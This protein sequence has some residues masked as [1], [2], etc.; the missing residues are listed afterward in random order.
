MIRSNG[1]ADRLD[2]ISQRIE[3]LVLSRTVNRSAV[4]L[5][6]G[7]AA[8]GLPVVLASLLCNRTSPDVHAARP[9]A[10][11]ENA[12]PDTL[13][14][15]HRALDFGAVRVTDRFMWCIAIANRSRRDA[16]IDELSAGCN[17]TTISPH[18]L[19]IPPG[20][21]R[22]VTLVID[23]RRTAKNLAN[24][25]STRLTARL[26]GGMVQRWVVK[27][28]PIE[29]THE[30]SSTPLVFRLP[31]SEAGDPTPAPFATAERR[32]IFPVDAADAVVRPPIVEMEAACEN[33]LVRFNCSDPGACPAGRTAIT[34][35]VDGQQSSGERF[36]I[37][38]PGVVFKEP[39]YETVPSIVNFG[40]LTTGSNAE[41]DFAIQ[42]KFACTGIAFSTPTSMRELSVLSRP[43]CENSRSI[44]VQCAIAGARAGTHYAAIRCAAARPAGE[45]AFLVPVFYRG[46]GE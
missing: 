6:F 19:T 20:Q 7:L 44:R 27:G 8:V 13:F 22:R 41:S 24:E 37:S 14:I 39:A 5:I 17:C 2:G 10:R 25:F 4:I 16:I 42:L 9:N 35:V 26:A 31:Y 11:D 32:F 15:D 34:I 28:R 46:V 21:S 33:D 12:P 38:L 40:A 30:G 1:G 43:A 29:I 45:I 23:L 18:S 3:P 36:S